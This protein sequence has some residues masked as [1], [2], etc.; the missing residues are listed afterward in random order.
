LEG[1][2]RLG[3]GGAC[4][5][6]CEC[7]CECK[8]CALSSPAS[9]KR[10]CALSSPASG[11]RLEGRG[12]GGGWGGAL[13]LLAPC[14]FQPRHAPPHKHTCPPHPCVRAQVMKKLVDNLLE[15]GK[16]FEVEQ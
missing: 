11:K 8:S 16:S 13:C 6:P 5:L 15:A 2:R 4:L 3:G 14:P 12:V 1:G 10:S 7:G 9:G